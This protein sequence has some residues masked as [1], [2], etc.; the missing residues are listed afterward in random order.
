MKYDI[1][2]SYR[3]VG[4]YDTAKH[5]FDLLTH[6]GYNVSF[7]IDTFKQG[8]FEIESLK[9]INECTDFI[10]ILNKEVFDKCLDP[11]IDKKNDRLRTEL[12]YALEIKKNIIPV[13]LEG[14]TEFP[15]NLPDDISEISTKNGPKFDRYYFN[16]FYNRLKKDF[17]L[18]TKNKFF[19]KLKEHKI[20]TVAIVIFLAVAVGVFPSLLLAISIALPIF[21]PIAVGVFLWNKYKKK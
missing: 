14:F 17:L 18:T 7:D 6:D 12:A 21:L 9:R 16:E 10:L 15:S 11:N 3:R 13:M 8:D 20:F 1:F 5:L 2:I 19:I 4:G